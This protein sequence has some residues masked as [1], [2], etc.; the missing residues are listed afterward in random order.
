M[1]TTI[2]K[3]TYT[4]NFMKENDYIL[5]NILNPG[6]SN[7]DFKDIL[8]MNMENTQ[9]LPY[10][11]Y[12]SS[13]FITQNE[14]FQDNN[15]NFSEKKF[16]DFYTTNVGK[17]SSFNV[18][19]PV[20]ENF[21][22]SIFDSSRK[23][24]SR[25]K[26]PNFKFSVVSNPDRITT[27]ISGRNQREASKLSRS[28]MAQQ[29]KIWD[30]EKGEW[31]DYSPNDVSLVKNPVG[32][33][34]SLF[35]DPLVKAT[36]DE[37]GDHKDPITK[38]LVHH[39]KG[40]LKLNDEGQYFYETLGNRS[41]IGK[42]VLS[43]FD[44]LTVDGEGINKYDFIDS[45]GLDKSVVGTIAKT[46][47]TVAP[48][49]I[50]GPAAAIYSGALIAREMGKSL[51]MLYGMVSS[52]WGNEEDSKLLNTIAAYGD[53]FSGG[54]SE[55]SR[56]NTFTFENI[57]SLIG[58]VATQ[59][60]QQRAIAESVNK[61]RGSKKLV[62]EA[63]KKAAAHYELEARAIQQG[64]L[65]SLQ[66]GQMQGLSPLQ[67]IGDP[68][69]WQES[70][71][72]KA[73]IKKFVEPAE[74]LAKS[75]MRLGAD[76][77]L[78]YMAIVSNTDV[79][80][81]MLEHGASK[82]DAAA[83][84]FGS[85]LGMFAVDRYLGLGELFFDELR[86][87][88]QL[89]LRNAFRREAD[90]VAGK[91]IAPT[92]DQAIEGLIANPEVRQNAIKGFI[93]KGMNFSKGVTEKF[94]SDVK[95]HATG[96]I[97]KA[98]GEGLEEVS[99]ELVADLSK[100]LYE[101]ASEFSPNFINRSGITD[102][103][104]WENA[105]ER[106]LMSLL[107]GTIGGGLFYGVNVFQRG[108][109]KRDTTK[110]ELIYLVANNRTQEVLKELDK[111]K[112]A[113][114]FGSKT[115]SAS[116][117][118]YDS[119]GKPVFL[120]AENEDDS[121][122]TYIY[123][124]IKESVLQLENIL[125]QTGTN[126]SE[127]DLFKQMV[128]SEQRFLNLK[129]FLQTQSYTTKYQEQFRTIT[130]KLI[131]AEQ[132][133]SLANKTVDGTPTGEILP[134][135]P[136]A[137]VVN[138]PTRLAN[139]EKAKQ[140]VDGLKA[141]RDSFLSGEQSLPYTEKMLFAID[142]YLNGAFTS[143]TYDTWLQ[144]NKGKTVEELSPAEKQVFEE[145]YLEY[146][147]AADLDRSF[148]IYKAIKKIVDP[149][150]AQ[151]SEN[152]DAFQANHEALVKLFDENG[153][154]SKLVQISYEDKLEGESDEDY[155]NRNTQLEGET[156]EN[157]TERRAN[158]KDRI[159]QYNQQQL[160]ALSDSI[161]QLIQE[162]G[163]Y[164]DPSTQRFIH[165][166]FTTRRNDV[167]SSII[168]SF[169]AQRQYGIGPGTTMQVLET[170]KKLKPDMSN[171]NEVKQEMLDQVRAPH[172][173]NLEKRNRDLELVLHNLGVIFKDFGYQYD[174][175]AITGATVLD[176]INTLATRIQQ[177]DKDVE[178]QFEKMGRTDV[179]L[180]L[181][182]SDNILE[183]LMTLDSGEDGFLEYYFGEEHPENTNRV[184]DDEW[185]PF[186][187]SITVG[188]EEYDMHIYSQDEINSKVD[189]MSAQSVDYVEQTMA[190]L[191]D[192]IT[193][194]PFVQ[195]M[196]DVDAAVT[197][198]NPVTKLLKELNI[199]IGSQNRN[200]EDILDA[201]HRKSLN[202][203]SLDNF[204][205]S[206]DEE[207]SIRDA[208][209]LLATV[210]AYLY[211]AGA[212]TSYAFPVG[213]NKAIN[214]FAKK[215][216][217]IFKNFEELPTLDQSVADMY[218]V[219]ID[220]YLRELSEDSATS[221]ISLSNRNKINKRQKLIN[222]ESKF[223]QAK[224]EFLDMVNKSQ[225][226]QFIANGKSYNL[227]EG[228]DAISDENPAVRLHKIEDLFYTNLHKAMADGLTFKQI[229]SES[230]MLENLLDI[231][232]VALQT[233][234][235]LDDTISYGK[236]T[237]FDKLVYLLTISGISSNEFQNFI[238]ERVEE[239][240]QADPDKKIVPLT[241]QEQTSRIALAQIR[242]KDIFSQA[243]EYIK[244]T[245]GDERP[246]LD[247]LVFVDG[248]A[249][250]G[251]TQVIAKNASK[252]VQSDNIWLSAP[253]DTQLR[254]L[255]EVIG[256]GQTK[257]RTDL[258]NLIIDPQTYQ[259]I[260]QQM[261]D[262]S[263]AQKT[264]DLFSSTKIPGSTN[265]ANTL[266]LDA[267]TFNDIENLP[268]L[269]II[270]EVTHFSSLEMQILNAFAKK[271][272]ISILALGDTNQNGFTGV[273]RNIDREKIITIRSPKL[274]ISLRDVNLQ[275][276]ENLLNVLHILN[277][278]SKLEDNDP[279]YDQ[280]FKELTKL[281]GQI[282]FRVYNQEELNGDL[283]TQAL[284]SDQV[285]KMF[286]KVAFVGD[287][288]GDAYQ[289]LKEH[290]DNIEEVIVLQPDEVQGQE[291][292][293]IVIDQKWSLDTSKDIRVYNFLT[294]L[295]T[296]MSRGKVGSI[297][298]D[299]GLSNI[300]GPNKESLSKENAPNLRDAIEPFIEAKLDVLNQLE[301]VPNEEFELDSTEA[302]P[303]TGETTDDSTTGTTEDDTAN[304]GVLPEDETLQVEDVEE[305]PEEAE[306]DRKDM[307][308]TLED[309]TEEII[310][311]SMERIELDPDFPIRIYG[312]AHFAGLVKTE[313]DIDGKKTNIYVN[314]HSEVKSDLQIFMKGDEA[315]GEEMNS[316]VS[317]LLNLKSVILYGN[318]P[319]FLHS[320]VSSVVDAEHLKNIKFKIEVRPLQETDNFVG[321][322]G[323][324]QNGT[325][326]NRPDIGGLVYTLVGEFQNNA[327]EQC[328]VTLGLL[329]NPDSFFV[330]EQAK[331]KGKE[332]E[333]KS[334]IDRYRK[335]F[336]NITK[337][338][339]R[340]GKFIQ[341]V[342][343]Q[344]S[345]LTNIRR[346]TGVGSSRRPVQVR[347]LEAFKAKHPYT[348][349]SDPYIFIGKN[350]KG[351][352]ASKIR[353]HAVVFVSNDTTL[354][355]EELMQIY[356]EQKEATAAE[357]NADLFN[358]S[359]KPRVRMLML[360]PTG[361]SF[362]SLTFTKKM[363]DLYS[364]EQIING[365]KA[366]KMF[367]F[368][369]DYMGARMFTSL[370]NYRANLK[371]FLDAYSNF[372]WTLQ[373]GTKLS[374]ADITRIARYAD[375][376][377]K[378]GASS[379]SDLDDNIQEIL[380]TSSATE[381]EM[382]LLATFNDS[383]AS[384][385]RQFRIGG[386]RKQSGVYLRNLTN[387]SG[388]NTFYQG[389]EG[390]PIGIYITPQAAQK[391][392]NLINT[393]LDDVLG[394]IIE[395]KD[396]EGQMWPANRTI[397]SKEG[398]SNSLSGLITRAFAEGSINI[399][400]DGIDYTLQLPNHKTFVH[401]PILLQKIYQGLRR[402]QNDPEVNYENITIGEKSGNPQ[403]VNYSKMVKLLS[404]SAEDYF[405]SSF[406]DVLSLA[407]HGT[408][409][410]PTVSGMRA[411]DA[412]FK[413]G[414]YID[415]MGAEVVGETSTGAGLFKRCLTNG[416]L[417]TVNAETDMPIFTVTLTDLEKAYDNSTAAPVVQEEIVP[418]T[419][420]EYWSNPANVP[421]SVLNEV[422]ELFSTVKSLEEFYEKAS[423]IVNQHNQKE[424]IPSLF[425]NRVRP[426]QILDNTWYVDPTGEESKTVQQHLEELSGKSF[427]GAKMSWDG[428]N[429]LVTLSDGITHIKVGFDEFSS[430]FT[431]NTIIE[432]P[433]V[434]T[435]SIKEKATNKL[436]IAQKYIASYL[437]DPENAEKLEDFRSEYEMVYDELKTGMG[438]YASIEDLMKALKGME[439]PTD[440][441]DVILE[442]EGLV[443]SANEGLKC[444]Y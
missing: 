419:V 60:G 209:Q 321:F 29:A 127:D 229:L 232:K 386:S 1:E 44:T 15:G 134:D 355:P 224:L 212:D 106:Y 403:Q 7:Q 357:P 228:M 428:E 21:E 361:V 330:S 104:A 320:S 210:K 109:F 103:G 214:E 139:I 266:N 9:I 151:L 438:S 388:D 114:K 429:L 345:G 211:A 382:K 333:V 31:L 213:H 135:N 17:F 61:L 437:A 352:K 220:K 395:L 165:N 297:F 72:G 37:A 195:M 199:A 226:A 259:K 194:D 170:M 27:G 245:T 250:V 218:L 264:T 73:A 243:L 196:D 186:Y 189:E 56:Q 363:K 271:N 262:P 6:F 193:A 295:Y 125:N 323:L 26:D 82:R 23:L 444:K 133:L 247:Y 304:D 441:D 293:F 63:Y 58:D 248:S 421:P 251:K 387:I 227:L 442:I 236:L 272:G 393:L 368:E 11:S 415:P 159:T 119:G 111:W 129:D 337:Q 392:Y 42:E 405:D 390:T 110:D 179:L 142:K 309:K 175:N 311:K 107:G 317:S 427:E 418:Q 301:L 371:K 98:V 339:Q 261:K 354:K 298:V 154:M 5:A 215:H 336:E 113:G 417:L 249:G 38:R 162:A 305:T 2:G 120:T 49:F 394:N 252:F 412:Y 238:K 347:T 202:I 331:N 329:A 267:I 94:A 147:Q 67:Y 155:A 118:E 158:R 404:P 169:I 313:R 360:D 334:K 115:L 25:V 145:E 50:G 258:F 285:G 374:D 342:T 74:K 254:T 96:F 138:D 260:L 45:D 397:S 204:S 349:V 95:N 173:K 87:G 324:E 277:N 268:E 43:A 132:N 191:R 157:F 402:L 380:S 376:I 153:P 35:D 413:N 312:S 198:T 85:T 420:K 79:Y 270:D 423:D 66:K 296:M 291:F 171:F 192:E 399:S 348:V 36:W 306:Q 136:N 396:K 40:D 128:L 341:D 340:D 33:F 83:V 47:L 93:K 206:E 16:K 200:I 13:P 430:D 101:I 325:E 205:L 235:E 131:E 300:I 62:E 137:Q 307:I 130:R 315:D 8:G 166:S 51:P 434:G 255:K 289:K 122:N 65:T 263:N 241:I 398:Y 117:Y 326:G 19:Q 414:I 308:E 81:S 290:G 41:P 379:E 141:Q 172:R 372:N 14:L 84:A 185:I 274:S 407:F 436:Q 338:Y 294:D 422:Q 219:E 364:T 335:V 432:S 121:Q 59:W 283:L 370:W 433:E 78:A 76:A 327:G 100:Q 178:Q 187:N 183:D 207:Q 332:T 91:L 319:R 161:H 401:V 217:S 68:A 359:T 351:L 180:S 52:L 105:K 284:T 375:A 440:W 240:Q 362:K 144:A 278:M 225:A 80:Q 89:A 424:A 322:T 18:D 302:A 286:G 112:A 384:E 366:I 143:M 190:Q 383:L 400:E 160:Q 275:K 234:S 256:K 287:T 140:E 377:H 411:T 99:E 410:D 280:K 32:W 30:S 146:K 69:K 176:F 20:V 70:A 431:V 273:S 126:L 188:Q 48:L 97:G 86:N 358:L 310:E 90:A 356:I 208:E 181:M 378:K 282:N 353:G 350:F 253:K 435:G 124:R 257:S 57:A 167:A 385:V 408:T 439:E 344:F 265:W 163:G 276:Q 12:T 10:S 75:N 288:N 116:K 279:L 406:D 373:D 4:W 164:I 246:I 343:P 299:N 281:I 92:R 149:H 426:A 239:S 365:K 46:A 314:P 64:A 222:A 156:D 177:G 367:P 123:N 55:Y 233:T 152:A 318:D 108:S 221:W 148:E 102:V 242:N 269:I 182:D 231:N 88:T 223:N 34:K 150:I 244:E 237:D 389:I 216:S 328:K 391:Q 54:T 203:D 303:P 28:E 416:N 24:N 230:K 71:L 409:A 369:E 346:T 381:E 443:S 201:L 77:S 39:E 53:K 3:T 292:D 197:S 168:S 22:Y 425:S 184:Y 174:P 316:L